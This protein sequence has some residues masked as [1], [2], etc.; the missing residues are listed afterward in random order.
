MRADTESLNAQLELAFH[1]QRLPAWGAPRQT[2]V[3]MLAALAE[4]AWALHV[5]EREVSRQQAPP[6]RAA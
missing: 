3:V 2:V 6:V 5:W 1:K 4:N